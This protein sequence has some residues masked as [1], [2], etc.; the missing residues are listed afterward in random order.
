M[1]SRSYACLVLALAGT[2]EHG[3]IARLQEQKARLSISSRVN[4]ASSLAAAGK[5]RD[6]TALLSSIGMGAAK[7]IERDLSRCLNSTHRD[8]AVLLSA[9]L[10]VEP[11]NP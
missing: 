3:W 6:A 7:P 10:D 9:W 8:E 4:L 11:G 1:E 5:Q 2:P